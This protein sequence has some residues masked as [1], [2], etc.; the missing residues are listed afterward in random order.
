MHQVKAAISSFSNVKFSAFLLFYIIWNW[1]SLDFG[2]F[3]DK[4]QEIMS[5]FQ[6]F[7]MFRRTDG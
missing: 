7:L 1:I 2:L 5:T 6:S 3:V 4:K